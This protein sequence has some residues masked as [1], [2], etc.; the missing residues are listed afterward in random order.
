LSRSSINRPCL[1]VHPGND[2][3]K[4]IKTF[5]ERNKVKTLNVAGPRG[6]NEPGTYDYVTE[7]LERTFGR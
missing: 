1:H 6:S 7:V 2:D 5:L 4:T 3:P